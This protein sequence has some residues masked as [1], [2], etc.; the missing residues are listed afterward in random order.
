MNADYTGLD[1]NEKEEY[2]T[3]RFAELKLREE[4]LK[5]DVVESE[6]VQKEIQKAKPKQSKITSFFK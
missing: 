6:E 2:L 3:E 5:D 4:S 1:E